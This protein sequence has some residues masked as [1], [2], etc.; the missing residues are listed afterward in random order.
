[1]FVRSHPSYQRVQYNQTH[2]PAHGRTTCP[3]AASAYPLM[4]FGEHRGVPLDQVPNSYL[5]WLTMW[6]AEFHCCYDLNCEGECG[7][8]ERARRLVMSHC[9]RAG[10]GDTCASC[11]ALRFLARH[12]EIVCAARE[13]VQLRGLC[14]NC[15]TQM[16]PIGYAR[17]NGRNHADWTARF[18]HKQCWRT[19]LNQ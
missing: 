2:R 15:W 16:P 10:C 14:I 18:L 3:M 8:V 12:H 7:G 4:P 9:P 5:G 13:L 11:A 6:H 17:Q 19:L 1:M